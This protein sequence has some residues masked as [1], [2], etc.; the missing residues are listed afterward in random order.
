MATGTGIGFALAFMLF[1]TDG[2]RS[3]DLGWLALA[4]GIP[5]LAIIL[6]RYT[7][8]LISSRTERRTVTYGEY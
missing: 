6:P 1:P 8:F 4:L 3:L 2:G 5:V 7:R